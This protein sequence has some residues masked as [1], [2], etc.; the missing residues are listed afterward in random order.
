MAANLITSGERDCSVIKSQIMDA[1]CEVDN[2]EYVAIVDRSFQ[3]IDSVVIG[4]SIILIAAWV[5]QPRLID[6]LWV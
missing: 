3:E 6:N 2:I 5:G 1:L 4:G